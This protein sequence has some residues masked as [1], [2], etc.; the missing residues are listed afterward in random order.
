MPDLHTWSQSIYQMTY[1]AVIESNFL[2]VNMK[3]TQYCPHFTKSVHHTRQPLIG[4]TH[5]YFM[6]HVLRCVG[7]HSELQRPE[8]CESNYR[9]NG[10]STYVFQL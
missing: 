7:V 8:P 1:Y 6:Q 2:F 9:C 10:C 4:L 3:N 5:A